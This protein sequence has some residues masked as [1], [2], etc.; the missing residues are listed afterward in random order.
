MANVQ[1]ITL[2]VPD[3]SCAHCVQ[4]INGAL[5][6]LSGVETV[7]TDIATKSVHLRYDPDQVSLEKIEAELDEAGYTVAKGPQPRP[8]T[9][10]KPLNLA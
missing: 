2:S 1:E 7:S 10:G 4:T 9:S 6:A 8:R 5:G 3:V